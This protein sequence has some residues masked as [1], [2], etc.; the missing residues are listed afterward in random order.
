MTQISLHTILKVSFKFFAKVNFL[1]SPWAMCCGS[2]GC[3]GPWLSLLSVK[4]LLDDFGVENSRSETTWKWQKKWREMEKFQCLWDVATFLELLWV[5]LSKFN[6]VLKPDTS[7]VIRLWC[8]VPLYLSNNLHFRS[9]HHKKSL[10][11][12]RNFLHFVLTTTPNDANFATSQRNSAWNSQLRFEVHDL[13][14]NYVMKLPV[15]S[16]LRKPFVKSS[17]KGTVKTET[18][19]IPPTNHKGHRQSSEPIKIRSTCM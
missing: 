19:A 5:M 3:S 16:E 9:K 13:I 7:H 18:K 14:D 4:L 11:W 6:N 15:H 2:W 17:V 1:F 8:G 10:A 12:L